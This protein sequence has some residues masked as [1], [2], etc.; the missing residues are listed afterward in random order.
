MSAEFAQ[1]G[2]CA[3]S[4]KT[5]SRIYHNF[6]A[7]WLLLHTISEHFATF[8]WNLGESLANPFQAIRQR[9]EWS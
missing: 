2:A 5:P 6:M 4:D 9:F 1:R 3:G 8:V 7:I